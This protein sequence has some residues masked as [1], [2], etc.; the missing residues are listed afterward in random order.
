MKLSQRNMFAKTFAT[1]L[2]FLSFAA[3][4][5]TFWKGQ[6]SDSDFYNRDN[7]MNWWNANYVFGGGQLGILPD[8]GSYVTFANAA[9]VPQGLWVENANKGGVEWSLA[10]GAEEGAGL[11]IT[12]SLTIGTGKAGQLTI[13]SGEYLVR[14]T[15]NVAAGIGTDNGGSGESTLTLTNCTLTANKVLVATDAANGANGAIVVNAGA[16]LNS[17]ADS[18]DV[19]AICKGKAGYT[20]S[21]GSLTINGGVVNVASDLYT[22]QDSGTG[23]ITINGGELNVAKSSIISRGWSTASSSTVNMNGGKYWTGSAFE[24]AAAANRTASEGMLNMN[25]GELAVG[26]HMYLGGSGGGASRATVNMDGGMMSVTNHMHIA[27]GSGSAVN[28]YMNGG[29]VY[30]GNQFWLGNG[31]NS[32]GTFIMTNGNVTVNS[33]TCVGY[34]SGGTGH[35]I[36]NGGSYYENSEKFIIGQANGSEGTYGECIVSNGTINVPTLWIAENQKPGILTMEGG[37][38]IVRGEAQMSRNT[39]ASKGTINLNGGVL[40]VHHFSSSSGT[41]G[42]VTFNGGILKAMDNHGDWIPDIAN[43]EFKIA[44]GGAVFDTNGKNVT[45]AD[46]LENADGL[47][48]NGMIW[49]KGL[50]TL[51]ISSDLDLER[52][53]KFTIDTDLGE[54]GIGPIALTGTNNTLAAGK[55]ITVDVRPENLTTETYYP[56]ITGLTNEITMASIEITGDTF[57]VYTGK[58][59]NGTLSVSA[60]LREGA[61]AKARY[62]DNAWKFYDN[63]GNVLSAD[64]EESIHTYYVFTGAEPVA[65]LL[66]KAS[67]NKIMLEAAKSGGNAVTNTIAIPS[68]FAPKY[69][70]VETEASCAVVLSGEFVFTPVKFA[71]RGTLAFD[72]N[73]TANAEFT[74]GTISIAEGAVLHLAKSQTITA[75][76]EGEGEMVVDDGVTLT[77]GATGSGDTFK[78]G[79]EWFQSFEGTLTVASGATLTDLTDLHGEND[80]Q[81]PYYFLGTGTTL[82]MAGGTVSRFGGSTN[83]ENI[84]DVVIAEGTTNVWNNYQSRSGWTGVNLNLTGTLS[85]TGTLQANCGGRAYRFFSDLSEFGGVVEMSGSA[86]EFRQPISGGT[87]IA[88]PTAVLQGFLGNVRSEVAVTNAT[89]VLKGSHVLVLDDKSNVTSTG[90]YTIGADATLGVA[91]NA[92]VEGIS[93]A[94]GATVEMLDDGA[95]SDTTQTYVALTSKTPVTGRMPALVQP[96]GIHGKWKLVAREV[97]ENETTVYQLCAEY[98][99]AGFV[100]IIQ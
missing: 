43:C 68:D 96:E 34:G 84:Q 41:G 3:L 11:T 26:G 71:N 62:V 51:T 19:F 23:T 91:E 4:A 50:G 67:T 30:C 95:L 25:D 31:S 5:D 39:N 15:I 77:V 40:A 24:L 58:I 99:Q 14:D 75:Y 42:E 61:P 44:E 13:K 92:T 54:A 80:G 87:W 85:G 22:C 1:G 81:G 86:F 35:F 94:K 38:F 73:I 56:L 12:N 69:L 100:I 33:Y 83:N 29:E 64:T 63:D 78:R 10:D 70:A 46:T 57:F 90:T 59:E 52:T 27:D 72:G 66:A 28:F 49:K 36:M 21:Q 82:K 48:G 98:R 79:T 88:N 7:W 37:E 89:L 97:A 18:G 60:S 45:V 17:L 76:V 74:S 55:K 9:A 20:E 2:A 93:F 53:F 32:D 16:T 6:G 47:E 65:D 8:E